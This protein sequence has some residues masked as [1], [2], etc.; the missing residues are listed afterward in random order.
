M[1]DIRARMILIG[2]LAL[3]S[4]LQLL[5]KQHKQRVVDAQTGRMKDTSV[6]RVPINLGL[7]LQAAHVAVEQSQF[8]IDGRQSRTSP[9]N[10]LGALPEENEVPVG[11]EGDGTKVPRGNRRMLAGESNRFCV[12]FLHLRNW[13]T[14]IGVKAVTSH[15]SN[16]R[17][18]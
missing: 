7:D 3:L 2:V 5:P 6:R 13:P 10:S 11:H 16:P 4:I 18:I 9:R 14:E 15:G 1:R 12:T 17:F 8:F